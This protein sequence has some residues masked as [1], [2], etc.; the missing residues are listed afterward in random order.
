M[1]PRQKPKTHAGLEPWTAVPNFFLDKLLGV[2]PPPH[3]K[4][5]LFIW[6][7]IYGKRTRGKLLVSMTEIQRETR[8][9][10]ATVAQ[11]LQW[12]AE[13]ALVGRRHRG[14]RQ[15]NELTLNFHPNQRLVLE[16][17]TELVL[18]S[19]VKRRARGASESKAAQHNPAGGE[20]RDRST[21]YARETDDCL[22]GIPDQYDRQTL[23]KIC[24][25]DASK[26]A[27]GSSTQSPTGAVVRS[28]DERLR[29]KLKDMLKKKSFP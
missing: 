13:T 17:L 14:Y 2:L 29:E 6:R 26:D 7:T 11:S 12:F 1:D 10:R 27:S 8:V 5:L 21:A 19:K 25:K 24:V 16:T 23:L 9:S 18:A 22:T 3:F 20:R 15:T 28:A 4:V